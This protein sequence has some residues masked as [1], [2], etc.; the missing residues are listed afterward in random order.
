LNFDKELKTMKNLFLLLFV[1]ICALGADQYSVPLPTGRKSV[2]F[3]T[4]GKSIY[5]ASTGKVSVFDIETKTLTK[6]ISFGTALASQVPLGSC[7]WGNNLVVLTA[8]VVN[9]SFPPG[10]ERV[11]VIDQQSGS[12][13]GDF[14]PGMM[15]DH[16]VADTD[17]NFLYIAGFSYSIGLISLN[18]AVGIIDRQFKLVKT[19]DI[20]ELSPHFF[21]M[22]SLNLVSPGKFYAVTSAPARLTGTVSDQTYLLVIQGGELK[23]K[24]SLDF[25]HNQTTVSPDGQRVYMPMP[26]GGHIM[27]VFDAISDELIETDTSEFFSLMAFAG[28]PHLSYSLRGYW[29]LLYDPIAKKL[30][31]FVPLPDAIS[32]IFGIYAI[33]QP[34]FDLLATL[35]TDQLIMQE[36]PRIPGILA[37]ANGASFETESVVSPGEWI[38]PFGRSLSF[39]RVKADKTPL[40]TGLESTK[41]WVQAGDSE[42]IALPIAFASINQINAQF[43]YK[44]LAGSQTK[45]WVEG[46]GSQRSEPVMVSVVAATPALFVWPDKSPIMADLNGQMIF[47]ATPG[48]VVTF[49]ATGLGQIY[50][51]LSSGVPAPFDQLVQTVAKPDVLLAGQLCEVLFSGLSPGWVGLY[52]INLVVPPDVPAGKQNLVISQAG[53]N[54]LEYN[55][56]ILGGSNQ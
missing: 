49:Y 22:L 35:Y 44:I 21:S 13:V 34:A 12:V 38:S 23:K 15:A 42:P 6:E 1:S 3:S 36:I 9:N 33:R 47:S 37:L 14:W 54:S 25:A 43:P 19:V 48:N 51:Q 29:F 26:S 16:C 2:N 24:I 20:K 39:R 18:M 53:N 27:A 10:V 40:P 5:V 41:V 11:I 45:I 28:D 30:V 56:T 7:V 46:P 32:A 17:N 55:I 52:Q 31:A 50:P 4:D 8:L